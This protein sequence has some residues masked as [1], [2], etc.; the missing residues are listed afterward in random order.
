MASE[1]DLNSPDFGGSKA[2]GFATAAMVQSAKGQPKWVR[3]LVMIFAAIILLVTLAGAFDKLTS[4][5]SLPACDA[6]GPQQAEQGQRVQIQLHQEGR[7]D[8]HGSQM[9]R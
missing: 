9:R 3:I 5:G 4:M 7:G 8:R 2:T 1:Q 6:V